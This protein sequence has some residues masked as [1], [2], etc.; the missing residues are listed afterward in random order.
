MTLGAGS[1]RKQFLMYELCGSRWA[2]LMPECLQDALTQHYIKKTNRKYE[3]YLEFL[4]RERERHS[5]D[6]SAQQ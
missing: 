5:D 6:T 3:K 1:V 4:R 2:W